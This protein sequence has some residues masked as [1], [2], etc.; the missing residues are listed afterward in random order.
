MINITIKFHKAQKRIFDALKNHKYVVFTKGR[1]FGFTYGAMQYALASLLI[2]R[3]KKI[4]WGDTIYANI[5]RYIERYGIPF[6]KQIPPELWVWNKQK[7]E[8]KFFINGEERIIDFR[9]ADKPQ[10]WEGFGYDLIILNEAGIILK[11]RYLWENA[12]L[13]MM[14]DNKDSK[15]VIG[16]AP[17]GKNL[18]YEL[19]ERALQGEPGYI[20]FKFS[21]YDNPL[22][23]PEEIK[24]LEKTLPPEVVRQEIYG[25]FIDSAEL[26]VIKDFT[27]TDK[28][29]DKARSI[30]ITVDPAYEGG[31]ASGFAI[32]KDNVI[33][34]IHE[35]IFSSKQDLLA[36]INTLVAENYNNAEELHLIIETDGV[37]Y[38][39]YEDSLNLTEL[40]N[41][42]IKGVKVGGKP[43][44]G[45]HIYKNKR[46]QNYFTARE[47]LAKGEVKLYKGI[48]QEYLNELSTVKYEVGEDGKIKI[49]SK[50]DYR[51]EYAKS[52]NI[53]DAVALLF[54]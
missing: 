42:Y 25:E 30:T 12:V 7:Q 6:L 4:L 35:R 22:I 43:T 16:G 39:V 21:S 34:D 32:M 33:V 52:P 49:Q 28:A 51:A 36:Y 38:A 41:T 17:K 45:A 27:L 9:S 1:R 37:G 31:D 19:Y 10:N 47:M 3:Y 50:K 14:L 11:N 48:K 40:P 44:K 54:A 46:A 20:A 8:I 5:S 29:P 26:A 53:A 23:D 13:P 18:F 15:A 24:R 2:G